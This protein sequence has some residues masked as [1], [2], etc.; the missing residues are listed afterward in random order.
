MRKELNYKKYSELKSG[1][2][3]QEVLVEM[4]FESFALLGRLVD[5]LEKANR[6]KVPLNVQKLKKGL[7]NA[8][9]RDRRKVKSSITDY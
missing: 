8:T 6:N 1:K 4:A 3:R 2:E 5:V 9:G 7:A